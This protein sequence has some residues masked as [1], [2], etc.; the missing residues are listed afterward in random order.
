MITKTVQAKSTKMMYPI[1]R[2]LGKL[3]FL[4]SCFSG[5]FFVPK[6]S[7][8]DITAPRF[9]EFNVQPTAGNSTPNFPGFQP[10]AAPQTQPNYKVQAALR[11][12]IKL[13]GNTKI[14]GELKHKNDFINGYYSIEDDHFEQLQLRQSKGSIIVFSQLNERWKFTNMLSA[15]SNSTDFIS[16]N[17]NNMQFRNIS[18]FEKEMKNG[19]TIGF[20]GSVTYDQNLTVIPIFKYETD[21]GNG[22]NLDMVLPKEIEVSKK[23][24]KSSRLSFEVKGSGSNFTLGNQQIANDLSNVS[25]YKR[26]DLT[27]T[28]G[29]QKQVTPWVGFSVN[30]GAMMPISSGIYANDSN[31]TQLY[32]FKQGIS[33]YFRVG[34]FLSLPN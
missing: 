30:A 21:F 27:G 5:L 15:S 17:S 26:M 9:F 29:Y 1:K 20:G 23:L 2:L 16:T 34:V 12:P 33:P 25:I 24:S 13:K 18:M 31:Q 8:Q 6:A 22:W 7:A 3:A 11:F 14:I 4:F 10:N 28:I 32:D 19:A